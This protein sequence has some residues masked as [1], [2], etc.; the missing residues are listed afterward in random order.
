[1]VRRRVACNRA[2]Y[3]MQG[4]TTHHVRLEGLDNAQ[5]GVAL[6][7]V[8]RAEVDR[9]EPGSDGG[10]EG[11]SE[12]R[13]EDGQDKCEASEVHDG[14]FGAM[15]WAITIGCGLV[16]GKEGASTKLTKLGV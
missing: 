7:K 15:W 14:G 4:T 12:S 16:S 13:A 5:Y 1:M 6:D 8:R 10:D 11:E 3:R 9:S 2:V